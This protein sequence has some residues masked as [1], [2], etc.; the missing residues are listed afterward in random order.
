MPHVTVVGDLPGTLE[1]IA[2]RAEQL[3]LR[4]HAVDA[5][6]TT[7][8]WTRDNYYRSFYVR[9]DETPQFTK[10]YEDTCAVL[11]KCQTRP[12]HMSLMY[13]NKLPDTVK[14][15]LRDSLYAAAGAPI[16]GAQVKLTRMVVCSTAGLPPERWTCP[17]E[18]RLP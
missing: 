11:G 7:I 12:Y 14:A 8:E 17:K 13:T 18:V 9:I 1:D 2:H 10:L 15:R 16:V 4:T 5:R 6:L 3:A